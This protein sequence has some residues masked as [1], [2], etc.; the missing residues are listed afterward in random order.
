M[1]DINRPL[2]TAYVSSLA[3]LAYD[4]DPINTYYQNGPDDDNE[5]IFVV[6]TPVASIGNGDKSFQQTAT[7][8]QLT[9]ITK[10]EKYNDGIAC[11][12][13]AGQILTAIYPNSQAKLNLS[14]GVNT[15]I[16]LASDNILPF[17][18]YNQLNYISRILVFRHQ[19]LHN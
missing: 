6:M 3:G 13:I 18:M 11:D 17:T 12:T 2:R 7:S 10:G 5:I 15:Q 19:I 16:E 14:N 1:I 4:G 9:V 8:M